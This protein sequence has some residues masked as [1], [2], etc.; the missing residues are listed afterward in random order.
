MVH[1][2]Q[3][4][5]WS[6]GYFPTYLF[7]HSQGHYVFRIRVPHDIIK[8]L[9]KTEIRRSVKTGTRTKALRR[10]IRMYELMQAVFAE[11]RKGGRMAELSKAEINGLLDKWI[12]RELQEDEERR[13]DRSNPQSY[14][15]H[16]RYSLDP[17]LT[18]IAIQIFSKDFHI[19]R[20][21][22]EK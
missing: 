15:E 1:K 19:R 20:R 12:K 8:T 22:F 6:T 16:V 11:I 10:G 7:L 3:K 13:V 9:D 18:S 17:F 21:Y 5:G 14:V 2:T 4:G